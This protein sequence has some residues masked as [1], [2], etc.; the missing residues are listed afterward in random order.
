MINFSVK[1]NSINKESGGSKSLP[2][3]ESLPMTKMNSGEG[4]SGELEE[5][6][7]PLE[8]AC[9][10]KSVEHQQTISGE[11]E[12]EAMEVQDEIQI[13]ESGEAGAEVNEMA[14]T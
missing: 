6:K 9:A 2:K 3:L 7:D 8:D 1:L 13:S 10:F 5:M 4:M 11:P 14:R 12:A